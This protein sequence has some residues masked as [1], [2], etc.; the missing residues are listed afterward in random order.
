MFERWYRA[1]SKETDVRLFNDIIGLL[2]G[3]P[4][5]TENLGG[6]PLV[7]VVVETDGSVETSGAL[8]SA[9]RAAA[10]TGRS[11]A[12]HAFDDVLGL[13]G[14]VA[15]QAGTDGLADACRACRLRAVCG[16]GLPAHRYRADNG[17]DNPSVYC[18]DLYCLIDHVR[19]T[20]ERDIAALRGAIS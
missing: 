18:P 3:R 7:S 12:R 14:V 10:A 15:L 1:A 17:L 19:G 8:S 20:V 2:L 9:Y 11:V 16:G 5:G 4:A 6:A 13:P